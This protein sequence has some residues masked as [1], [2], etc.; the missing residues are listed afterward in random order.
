MRQMK[1]TVEQYYQKISDVIGSIAWVCFIVG[2]TVGYSPLSKLSLLVVLLD[3]AVGIYI[4]RKRMSGLKLVMVGSIVSL[5]FLI[6]V[7]LGFYRLVLVCFVAFMIVT[8]VLRGVKK[9]PLGI[10]HLVRTHNL[11]SGHDSNKI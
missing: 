1:G 7:V 2:V 8:L 6:G 9:L 10:R 3:V 11:I 5:I 4:Y